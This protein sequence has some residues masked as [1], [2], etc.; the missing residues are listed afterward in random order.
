MCV[1]VYIHTHAR[2]SLQE[3]EEGIES[4]E[5]GVMGGRE[6]PDVGAVN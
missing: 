3:P 6:V 4:S 5:A 1:L 2:E